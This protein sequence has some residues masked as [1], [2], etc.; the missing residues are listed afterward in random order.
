MRLTFDPNLNHCIKLTM[1]SHR[2]AE[3]GI[4]VAPELVQDYDVQ[5]IKDGEVVAKKQVR[6][7]YQ[8][9]NIIDFDKTACDEIVVRV[10]ETHGYADARVYEVRAY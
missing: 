10:H 7:N 5:L 3:Q 2:M 4:G 8:R 1:S 9:H 6:G